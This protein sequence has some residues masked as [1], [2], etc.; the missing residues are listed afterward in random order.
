MSSKHPDLESILHSVKHGGVEKEKK[1]NIN[2]KEDKKTNDKKERQKAIKYETKNTRTKE[3]IQ[4]LEIFFCE[5]SSS[6]S[7]YRKLKT[8]V[9]ILSDV[10]DEEENEED[11]ENKN[12]E[13]PFLLQQLMS[14]LIRI[15]QNRVLSKRMIDVF[16]GSTLQGKLL[17]YAWTRLRWMIDAIWKNRS[18]VNWWMAVTRSELYVGYVFSNETAKDSDRF[19]AEF[20]H[21]VSLALSGSIV[22]SDVITEYNNAI[23]WMVQF[24]GDLYKHIMDSDGSRYL[25]LQPLFQ[26]TRQFYKLIFDVRDMSQMEYSP[27]IPLECCIDRVTTFMPLPNA[28]VVIQVSR[29]NLL[30]TSIEEV[31][32]YDADDW[33]ECNTMDVIYIEDSGTGVGLVLDW[34]CSV[35]D[36]LFYKSPYF[37][38]LPE[39]PLVVHPVQLHI[40]TMPSI[41]EFAGRLIG[42]ALKIDVP[43]GVHFSDACIKMM[44]RGSV[45]LGTFRQLDPQA[46]LSLTKLVDMNEEEFASMDLDQ[47]FISYASALELFPGGQKIPILYELREEYVNLMALS[48]QC[49]SFMHCRLM[50]KGMFDVLHSNNV[51]T[52][53]LELAKLAL[54]PSSPSPFN[55]LVGGRGLGAIVPLNEWKSC[56]TLAYV[57]Y[58]PLI[59]VFDEWA[60]G[61]KNLF[62]KMVEEMSGEQRL[63][64][65][66]F[67]TGLRCLPKSDFEGFNLRIVIHFHAPLNRLPTSQ[68][69]MTAIQ[70]PAYTDLEMMRRSFE[71]AVMDETMDNE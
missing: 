44:T 5:K 22:R 46:Y 63:R 32:K 55:A 19:K 61:F 3:L 20:E 16:D 59:Q 47:G 9:E 51:D 37:E 15:R 25:L 50:R 48:Q 17:D 52:I 13:E 64:L 7:L 68:T 56:T 29:A 21:V 10:K 70:M 14:V 6:S 4:N 71:V 23:C 11:E 57:G 28:D 27:D 54:S 60:E 62:F 35:A 2:E 34:I 49:M 66:R 39:E 65:L 24:A 40:H 53:E 33:F 12:E 45:D 67:W 58:S 31:M 42:L 69:C 30:Q 43:I 8:A 18:S 41:Y 1:D 36:E 26:W 38:R